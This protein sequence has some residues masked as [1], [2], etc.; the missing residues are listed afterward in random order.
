MSRSNFLWRVLAF[1][2]LVFAFGLAVYRA[3]VQ[4][5]AHD[6]ALEYEW[7][8]DGGVSH[9]LTY[10]AANHVLF[11]LLAKPIVWTLGVSELTLRAPSLFGAALYLIAT[12]LLCKRLFGEGLLLLLS[13]TMLSLNPQI[14]DFMPAARGYSLGLGFLAAALYVL[15]CLAERGEFHPDDQEWRW[16]CAIASVFLAFSVAASFTNVVPAAA[17]T[18]VF[19]A[20]ALGGFP[21]LLKF[22]DR[23]L[24]VFAQYFIVPGVAVG[25]CILWPYLIQVRRTAAETNM[26]GAAD[27]LR[28]IFNA[29]FLYKWTDDLHTSLGAVAPSAGSWQERVSDLGVYLILP[30]LFFFVVF[31][32][33]LVSRAPAELR[34]SHTAQCRIFGGAAI[35]CVVLIAVLHAAVRINYP[36]SRYCLFFIPLF[37]IGSM[38]LAREVSSRF[39][40]SYW[41]AAG[42]LIAA[43]VVLDYALSV[44]TRYFRYHVYDVISR[45]LYQTIANDA[46]TRGLTSVR[47]GGTWWYEPEL[48]F[49]RRRY[50]AT[51]MAE[52]DIK[53]RSYFWQTPNSLTPADYDYFVFTP[54]GDPGLSGPRVRTLFRDAV[55]GITVVAIDK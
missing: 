46:S 54:A 52:Y 34:K 28:D 47:V 53:D 10:N 26:S 24:R 48:N 45:D 23:T 6:E 3:K 21:A 49:Y 42:L 20:A 27:S 16:G 22:G 35:A 38:L 41:K 8:L 14:L 12:F 17:L 40:R 55:R 51:W 32:L 9:V 31:G 33:I 18:L 37:T 30:L 44:Q 50:K 2:L 15:A 11:T 5:I 19:A 7:F 36:Y 29:S 39:P 1:A 4:P 13:V 43:V 25:F